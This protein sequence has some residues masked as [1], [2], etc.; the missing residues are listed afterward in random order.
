MPSPHRTDDKAE[1]ECRARGHRAGMG[2]TPRGQWKGQRGT[3]AV[4]KTQSSSMAKSPGLT[5]DSA[6]SNR[7]L[8]WAGY[9]PSLCLSLLICEAK[10]N[11]GIY[12]LGF[13]GTNTCARPSIIPGTE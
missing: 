5:P 11:D 2:D 9:L 3:R 4:T 6:A 7:V 12:L 1:A 10:A 8:P 13:C